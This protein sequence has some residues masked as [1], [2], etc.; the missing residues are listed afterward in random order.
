MDAY[1][2][3]GQDTA[4]V[5]QAD[6]FRTK[7][8]FVGLLSSAL[9]IDQT[10]NNDDYYASNAPDQYVIANPD[11]TFSV[12]GRARSNLNSA[13]TAA[14]LVIPPGLLLLGGLFLAAKLLK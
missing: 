14:G 5:Q 10:Y 11:G 9:G 3:N 2:V 4:Q 12:Q 13:S 8:L 1:A 7:R 6:E